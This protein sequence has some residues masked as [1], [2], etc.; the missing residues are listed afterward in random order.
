MNNTSCRQIGDNFLP[1]ES[2]LKGTELWQK[3]IQQMS[4]NENVPLFGK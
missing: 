1:G 4:F 2:P 3:Q